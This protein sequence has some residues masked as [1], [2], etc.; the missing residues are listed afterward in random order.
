MVFDFAV[1]SNLNLDNGRSFAFIYVTVTTGLGMIA[2]P[3]YSRSQL[4]RHTPRACEV[5][6][7][8][9]IL[10]SLEYWVLVHSRLMF[11]CTQSE[12]SS[13]CEC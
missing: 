10:W 7:N 6:A 4:W 1:C 5:T 8:M 3:S 11:V 12:P 13:P 9:V 2:M